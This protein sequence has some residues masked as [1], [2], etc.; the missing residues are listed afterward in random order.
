MGV[1]TGVGGGIIRDVLVSNIPYILKKHIY[2]VAAILGGLV[3]YLFYYL[4][5]SL[6]LGSILCIGIV[7]LIRILASTFKWSLPK[8]KEEEI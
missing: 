3:F 6:S 7:L 2:C 1:M 5:L 8:I 4:Q